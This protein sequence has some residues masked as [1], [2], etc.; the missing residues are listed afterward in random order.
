MGTVM[1]TAMD[2]DIIL[3][4]DT[5]MVTDMDITDTSLERGPLML[6]PLLMPSPLLLLSPDM[7]MVLMVSAMLTVMVLTDTDTPLPMLMDT[8]TAKDLLS[9]P[10]LLNLDTVTVMLT[11]TDMVTVTDTPMLD[12]TVTITAKGL[13]KPSPITVTVML[14]MPTMVTVMAVTVMVTVMATVMLMASKFI[15]LSF[16]SNYYNGCVYKK[17]YDSEN[18]DLRSTVPEVESHYARDFSHVICYSV[19]ISLIKFE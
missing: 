9:P 1:V 7:L 4:M 18:F 19:Q 2:T 12:I 11:D 13:L 16:L 14:L 5:V 8:I 10:L 15:L 17:F 6:N 3:V